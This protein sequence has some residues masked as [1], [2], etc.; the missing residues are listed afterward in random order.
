MR[1]PA[2]RG[3]PATLRCIVVPTVLL[4]RSIALC[5]L[6]FDMIRA[7]VSFRHGEKDTGANHGND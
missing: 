4:C 7:C 6:L 3:Y 5:P 2:P 1:P